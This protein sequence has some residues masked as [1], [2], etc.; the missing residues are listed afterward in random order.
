VVAV[1]GIRATA[2]LIGPA[3]LALIIVMAVTPLQDWML[4]RWLPRWLS[5]LALVVGVYAILLGVALIM[6]ISV[7][8]LG[9]LVPQYAG[10]ADALLRSLEGTLGGF[11]VSTDELR[12]A[13]QS[14]KLGKDCGA[15]RR[16]A[17][18]RGRAD[19]EPGV[20]FPR[21][22]GVFENW[23]DLEDQEGRLCCQHQG[24]TPMSC[25]NGQFGC[26]GSPSHGR[27]F[28]GWASS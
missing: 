5:V 27:R 24:S 1:A 11:N 9:G 26:I 15:G 21:F 6:I 3:F 14:V 4:R 10:Q 8:R 18:R 17:R 16:D 7:A 20:R 25:G 13:L 2:W 28:G 22:S 12:A 19:V 23:F